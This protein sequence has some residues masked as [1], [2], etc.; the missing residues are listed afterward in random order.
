MKIA[1]TLFLLISCTFFLYGQKQ[2]KTLSIELNELTL[3]QSF[4]QLEKISNHTI[5][6]DLNWLSKDKISKK[7]T[8][9]SITFILDSLLG[10]STL[11]YYILDD[12]KVIITNNIVIYDKLPENYFE[13]IDS[14]ITI[15]KSIV[16]PTIINKNIL[17]NQTIET[18]RLGKESTTNKKAFYKLSGIILDTETNLPLANVA[19][20]NQNNT[21]NAITNQNGYFELK[22]PAGFNS[23]ET[24]TLGYKKI[25]KNIIILNDANLNFKLSSASQELNEV[26][27]AYR[28]KQDI[29]STTTGKSTINSKET[30]NI[31]LVLGERDVLKIATLLPGVSTAGEGS[32]GFNV[33]GGKADQNLILLDDAV[34]YNPSHFFGIFQALNPFAIKEVNV[35][36]GN[37]P[38]EFGGRISSVFDIE[39]NKG[40]QEKVKG[41]F[42][43]SPVTA[44]ALVEMPLEKNKSSLLLGARGAYSDWILKLLNDSDLQ[45]SK[46]SFYDFIA[47]YHHTIN[48]K[49]NIKA[50][51]YYSRDNFSITS[52]SLYNYSNKLLSI[53]WNKI[54]DENNKASLLLTNSNYK[55]S[56]LFDKN[57]IDDFEQ[58]YSINETEIKLKLN[59]LRDKHKFTYGFSSK[60]YQILPGEIKP[61]NNSLVNPEALQKEKG[62]E[63][64]IFISDEYT[65]NDKNQMDI[66]IRYAIFNSLGPKTQRIYQDNIPKSDATATNTIEYANNKIIK[67]YTAPEFRIGFRHLLNEDSSLKLSFNNS[68]QFIHTLSN[69]TTVSPIDSWKL[70]DFYIKPQQAQQISLGYYKNFKEDIYEFSAETFY[71]KQQNIID[72]K[73]GSQLLMNKFVETEVLQGDGKAYGIE[74]LLK[75][76]IGKLSGWLSYTYSRALFRFRSQYFEEEINNGSF[77]PSNFDKPHDASLILNYKF[78][79]RLSFSSN[80]VY[81]TGR[82]VTLP[83]GNFEFNN[84]EFVLYSNRNQIRIPDF[85]RLDVGLNLEGNHKK[86]K[87]IHSFWSLSIYNVLG[88][89]NPYSV[90]FQNDEGSIK[91]LQSSIFAVPIPSLSYNISF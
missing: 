69:N 82:P 21:T 86:N 6:Y 38:I 48:A 62:L 28:T 17:Q 24:S 64:S 80:F 5:F 1:F 39:T 87:K 14:T 66:G 56:I 71:K 75:K 4:N 33:R 91:A 29:E 78:S 7:F 81:Q 36:K 49:N 43:I 72:F 65:I 40:G 85:Y 11:S 73:T 61:L 19:I 10:S 54:F 30:K 83:V 50:T 60:L 52:D 12:N 58:G 59:H 3:E 79:Q 74:F 22:L 8:D 31:P 13:E 53:K 18:I 27:L 25:I 20:F 68:I 37:V 90:F 84:S 67:T 26:V 23:I 45:N 16:T 44:N 57:S 2:N 63:S 41:Q 88:R 34:V 9:K 42:S 35:Y 89:N 70:S 55:F 51:A 77:F 76:K 32:L 46:A 47:N 15:E